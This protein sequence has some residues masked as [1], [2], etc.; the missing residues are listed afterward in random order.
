MASE[1]GM[2]ESMQ[3]KVGSIL[4][5]LAMIASASTAAADTVLDGTTEGG[6]YFRIVVPDNW[7][8]GLVVYNHGFSLAPAAPVTDL[9]PLAPLQLSEGYAVAASSYRTNG[10][11]LGHS[12]RDDK[13]MYQ[14]FKDNFGTPSHV[15]VNGAS[16]GGLVTA[17]INEN[18][19]SPLLAGS[20]PF[21]GAMAGSRSWDGALDLRLIYDNV[22]GSVPGAAIPG[23]AQG[24]PAPGFPLYPLSE[25]DMALAIHACTGILA[26]AAFRT[27]DQAARL[28]KILSVTT[29]PESFLLTDMGFAVFGMSDLIHNKAG[30]K[31][32]IGNKNV[33]YPDAAI[34]AS[35]VRVKPNATAAEKLYKNFTPQGDVPAH[36]KVLSLH[37]DKDG[38]VVV[39]QQHSYKT[40]MPAANLTTAIAVEAAPSHCGFTQ[41]E[42]VAGWEVLRSWVGTNAQPHA[43]HVQGLC[44]QLE[45]GGLA[46]G[47]CRIDPGYALNNLDTRILPR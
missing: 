11:A 31:Q 3:R 47:P 12:F 27:P 41:A 8:G 25:T 30:G 43:A 9:G 2:G 19:E 37:T 13:L 20:M 46:A 24:L 42:L 1:F 22:C 15:L 40:V 33:V 39:E 7:N 10:W 16:L 6:A 44:Q 21:C 45:L 17:E 23:G 34:N 28:A 18:V 32:P 38:L 5:A 29:I 4:M 14:A 26:P 35:I 36:T